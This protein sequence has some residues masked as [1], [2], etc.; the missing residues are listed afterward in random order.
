MSIILMPCLTVRWQEGIRCSSIR[1]PDD[2]RYC[3]GSTGG[4][5]HGLVKVT[6]S[7]C[8]GL[9]WSQTGYRTW[10]G[11]RTHPCGRGPQCRCDTCLACSQEDGLL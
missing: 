4:M 9:V 3:M 1:L 8:S 6:D 11:H 2:V 7:P 10:S 5:L